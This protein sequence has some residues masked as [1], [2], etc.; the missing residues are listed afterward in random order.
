MNFLITNSV[1]LNGGD[2]ALLRATIEALT[3]RYPNSKVTV[4]CS[5]L[6]LCRKYL[7]DIH[8]ASDLEFGQAKQSGR[9]VLELYQAS[10][11]VISA[12]GGFIHDFY[13]IEDRLRGFEVALDFGKPV[14]IF[15]QSMGPFWKPASLKRIPFVLN[16]MTRICVR[17]AISV[18]NLINCGVEKSRISQTAD[19]AFI[20]RRLALDEFH[21]KSG[22]VKTIGLC[23]RIWP[24]GDTTAV[25]E[26]IRKAT[27][28]CI[29]L[30]MEEDRQL[31]FI[32]TCQGVKGYVDDS[33]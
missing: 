16:R 30:L 26:T 11:I 27:Q 10:D 2:E 19:A 31:V 9:N 18:Q 25:I 22:P 28:L 29:H 5:Q 24:L 3:A 20:W 1:P 33:L 14:M 7:P 15:G 8:F 23:F 6:E 21:P 4:L 17:D 32:S 13:E 12:P